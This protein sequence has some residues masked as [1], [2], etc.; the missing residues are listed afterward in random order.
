[1]AR[2]AALLVAFANDAEHC[3]GVLDI[4]DLNLGRLANS[5]PQHAS[6]LSGDERLAGL[7]SHEATRGQLSTDFSERALSSRARVT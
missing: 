6:D 2:A 3:F 5:R 1:L 7:C 4:A